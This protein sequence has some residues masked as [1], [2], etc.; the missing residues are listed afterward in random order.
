LIPT[1]NSPKVIKEGT[2]YLAPIGLKV[3][4]SKYL[5]KK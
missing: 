5:N 2:K 4:I 1:I 3:K